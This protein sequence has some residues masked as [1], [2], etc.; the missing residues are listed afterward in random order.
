VVEKDIPEPGHVRI[1][2]R[3]C[4]ICHGDSITK[5]GLFPG[6]EYPMTPGH[7]IACIV[8]KVG[9]YVNE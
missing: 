8:D 5:E 3:A 4:G 7:E 1:K 9:N 6:I 2:V